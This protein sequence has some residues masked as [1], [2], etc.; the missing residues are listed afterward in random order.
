[1]V[2]VP[3]IVAA[4]V[5]AG[6]LRGRPQPELFVDELTLRPWQPADAPS[7]V[8]AY[9]DAAIQQWHARSMTAH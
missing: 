6:R 1:M 3:D 5:P 8:R 4:V 7:V 9:Q 2:A